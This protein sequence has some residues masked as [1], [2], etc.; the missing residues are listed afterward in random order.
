MIY[1][2]ILVTGIVTLLLTTTATAKESARC[3]GYLT[4]MVRNSNFPVRDVTNNKINLLIDDDQPN[5]IT[6]QVV[7]DVIPQ[8]D[9]SSFVS[10]GWI[11]YDVT[12]HILWNNSADLNEHPIK[13]SF[14][15]KY[16][17]GFDQCRKEKN[18]L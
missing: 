9:N 5:M 4:E 7:Y 18:G 2:R 17:G 8:P 11:K 15:Q 10:I 14:N 12:N 1:Q 13:L 6:A 3:Y 16:A